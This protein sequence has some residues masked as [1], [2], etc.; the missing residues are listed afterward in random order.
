MSKDKSSYNNTTGVETTLGCSSEFEEYKEHLAH[1]QK[2]APR[3]LR[4]AYIDYHISLPEYSRLCS[5]M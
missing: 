5:E 1:L 3:F 4:E 2:I